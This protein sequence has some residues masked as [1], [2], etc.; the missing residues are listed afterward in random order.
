[1]VQS[2]SLYDEHLLKAAPFDTEDN[3]PGGLASIARWRAERERATGMPPTREHATPHLDR[4]AARVVEGGRAETSSCVLGGAGEGKGLL[5][6]QRSLDVAKRSKRAEARDQAAAALSLAVDTGKRSFLE[7]RS[8]AEQLPE[9][10]PIFLR[11]QAE[12]T[13]TVGAFEVS[14]QPNGQGGAEPHRAPLHDDAPVTES[15]Q[16]WFEDRERL[17]RGAFDDGKYA[18][19]E[20]YLRQMLSVCVGETQG[21]SVLPALLYRLA[22]A[23]LRQRKSAT[24]EMPLRRALKLLEDK[25]GPDGGQRDKMKVLR[26]RVLQELALVCSLHAPGAKET[27]LMHAR[28]VALA[29]A[30]FGTSH[31]ATA[32]AL[33]QQGQAAIKSGDVGTAESALQR[34]H[35]LRA[36]KIGERHPKTGEVLCALAT[37]YR[38]AGRYERAARYD[39][40]WRACGPSHGKLVPDVGARRAAERRLERT[41][42]PQG[43]ALRLTNPNAEHL[44]LPPGRAADLRRQPPHSAVTPG[45]AHSG[46]QRTEGAPVLGRR[47]SIIHAMPSLK[48]SLVS[49]ED[50]TGLQDDTA[51]GHQRGAGEL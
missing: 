12:D 24:A 49:D 7:R 20:F 48:L 40:R 26:L 30:T 31:D 5:A 37:L 15:F 28:L 34:A 44:A 10:V 8:V 35:A 23:Q 22:Q 42:D 4:L 41:W 45:S 39:R 2:G 36:R 14:Q 6:R 18:Q 16:R 25:Y 32:A 1:M 47:Q 21:H 33:L 9:P 27:T 43:R 38:H 13:G 29:E 46:Q 3:A 17:A 51:S 50:R 11:V 19:A